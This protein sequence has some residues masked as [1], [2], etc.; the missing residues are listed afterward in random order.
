MN[1][2]SH[3]YFT[4][5]Y[6]ESR[7][8]EILIKIARYYLLSV[9]LSPSSKE[10]RVRINLG[11]SLIHASPRVKGFYPITYANEAHCEIG[12]LCYNLCKWPI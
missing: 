3:P 5:K 11:S 10:L 8:I 4:L 9:L 12:P 1:D 6:N 7:L 2:R